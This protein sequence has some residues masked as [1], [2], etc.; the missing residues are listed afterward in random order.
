MILEQRS[1]KKAAQSEPSQSGI[2]TSPVVSTEEVAPAGPGNGQGE[3][4]S[5]DD[6]IDDGLSNSGS[7]VDESDDQTVVSDESFGS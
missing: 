4:S 1:G 7:S 3:E 5:E 2:Q 6:G